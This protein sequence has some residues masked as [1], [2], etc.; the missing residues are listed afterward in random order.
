M[1]FNVSIIRYFCL[2]LAGLVCL[3]ACS[4]QE[5]KTVNP[6][7]KA[8]HLS[9]G[10]S[11]QSLDPHVATGVPAIKIL[12]G[13]GERL[14]SIDLTT[15]EVVPALATHWEISNDGKRYVFHLRKEGRWSDGSEVTAADFVY[16]WR[17]ALTPTVGWQYANDY[18]IIAGAEAFNKGEN[19]D[20]ASVGVKAL[21]AY[22]LEFTLR[23]AQPLF[24]RKLTPETLMPVH[25]AS[26]EKHGA[27]DDVSTAWTK[28]GNFVS[29]GAF[30]LLRWEVNKI[31]ELEKNPHYWNADSVKLDKIYL[32]PIETE[33]AEERA[34]RAGQINL[35]FGGRIPVSKIA[36]YQKKAPEK[37]KLVSAYATYFY[38]FNVTQPPFDDVRVRK[39]F[40]HAIDRDSIVKNITK[41]GE[42][43]ANTLT[44]P[45]PGYSEGVGVL[46]YDAELARKYLAEAGYPGGKDFP[47]ITLI[48]NTAD[49]HRKV[50][51]VIQQMWRTELGID[52]TLENQEWKV[53]LDT[54]Q[55]LNFNVARAGS[56]SG[57]ADPSDFLDTYQTGHGMNDTGWSNF[58]FDALIKLSS[59]TIDQS[60]RYRILAQAEAILLEE[61]PL[62][63][64]YYYTN[65]YLIDDTVKGL[66][67]NPI[68][69]INFS[70]IDIVNE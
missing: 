6:D 44:P 64:L 24:L 55:S 63:P 4:K 66:T 2:A 18:H 36:S 51:L 3:S 37:L 31:I 53:F 9:V 15:L 1:P 26:L 48:Y 8:L 12:T 54:R 40:T 70:D 23:S 43:V 5:N 28:A 52:V 49:L 17:R 42:G 11:P 25:Q 65:S 69:R 32:Y 50:A 67:F 57:I 10:A 41:A 62:I 19:T 56:V 29:N 38:L 61:L 27:M 21:D 14:V 20:F 58:E 7:E 47:S 46:T 34:F 39:A 60:E 30:R 45:T 16:A 68:S 35:A 13:L 33:S 22:T 59:E